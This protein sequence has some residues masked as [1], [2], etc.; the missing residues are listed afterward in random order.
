MA[1]QEAPASVYNRVPAVA[2]VQPQH[3][4]QEMVATVGRPEV[5]GVEVAQLWL[6][7]P[8]GAAMV[9]LVGAEKSGLFHMLLIR[10]HNAN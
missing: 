2:E 1:P 6:P 10:G 5:A 3:Q 4:Q 7:A 8:T 9:G